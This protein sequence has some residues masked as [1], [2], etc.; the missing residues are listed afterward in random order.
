MFRAFTLLVLFSF[1]ISSCKTDRKKTP[2][3]V[4]VAAAA[5]LRY[6]LDNINKAFEK[7]TGIKIEMSTAS[8][9]KLTAQ[10]Q[11]GAP[12]ELFLSANKK[13][14]D[15]LYENGFAL[16]E[17]KRIC[18]GILVLWTTKDIP[19]EQ[20]LNNLC[21]LK[22]KSLAIANP[23]NAPFG[24]AALETLKSLNVYKCFKSKII[25]TENVSQISQ[26]VVNQNADI[27]FTSKSIVLST[28]LKAKGK[29]IRLADTLYKPIN[30]YVILT[31][32][33]A[34]KKNAKS[35]YQFLFSEEAQKIFKENGY[36]TLK[37]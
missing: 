31:K 10:I 36:E 12:Y 3:T 28:Q 13:Y 5:N 27:G 21:S 22:I 34:N 35:Y 4:T 33:A 11:N 20:S 23:Q 16:T 14:P 25:Y 37:D 29:W 1:F 26:Y 15:Y 18:R 2:N 7:K 30:E 8:S 24:M 19:I 9:G 17:P 32:N 6:A